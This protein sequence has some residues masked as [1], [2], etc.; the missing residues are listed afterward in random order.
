MTAS[1]A[2]PPAASAMVMSAGEHTYSTAEDVLGV[3]VAL[4]RLAVF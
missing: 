1:V 2:A 3:V 4:Y